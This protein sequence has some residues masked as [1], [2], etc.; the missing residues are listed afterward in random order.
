[1]AALRWVDYLTRQPPQ[2]D[3]IPAR[4]SVATSDTVQQAFTR[5][6][7]AEAY[8]N[9]LAAIEHATPVDFYLYTAAAQSLGQA[10]LDVLETGQGADVALS[11]ARAKLEGTR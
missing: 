2:M 5:E 7:G 8:G 1:A 3:S 4:R 6:I 10:M 11:A 9:C